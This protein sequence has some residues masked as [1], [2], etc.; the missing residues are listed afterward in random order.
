MGT[1][2][3]RT[4]ITLAAGVV[5][6]LSVVGC[7]DFGAMAYFLMPEQRI[8]PKLKH[9]AVAKNDHKQDPKVVI[10]ATTAELETRTEFVQADRQLGELLA[11]ELKDLATEANEKL[12]IVPG[13]KVEE[14][15]NSHSEWKQMTPAEIGRKFDADHV[16]YLEINNMSLYEP[17]NNARDLMRGRA[18]ISVQ[19]IDV[20]KP[21]DLPRSETYTCIYPSEARGPVHLD[22]DVNPH[23][24]REQFLNCVARE[25]SHFFAKY[26]RDRRR[27]ME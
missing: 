27:R 5:G 12:T 1:F 7:G 13:R 24:F 14:F 25:L 3:R 9:L 6:G 10:W 2:S 19:L 8:E 22:M 4:F 15:R 21:D 26:P 17:G 20:N 11:R 18:N 23:M 16:I